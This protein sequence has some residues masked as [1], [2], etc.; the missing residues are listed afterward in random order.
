MAEEK[1]EN[2]YEYGR[3]A[4][5]KAQVYWMV[6]IQW[7]RNRRNDNRGSNGSVSVSRKVGSNKEADQPAYQTQDR[8]SGDGVLTGRIG[9]GISAAECGSSNGW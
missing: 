7:C 5:G 3:Y 4:I 8:G 2:E 9:H 1:Q 6:K